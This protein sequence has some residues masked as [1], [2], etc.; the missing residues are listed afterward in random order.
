M[1]SYVNYVS[2]LIKLSQAQNWYW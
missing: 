1:G 2:E